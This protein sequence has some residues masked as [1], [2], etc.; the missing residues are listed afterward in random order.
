MVVDLCGVRFL[1]V[2]GADW[3]DAAVG[4]LRE[5]GRTVRVVCADRGPVWRSVCLLGLDRQW[6]VHHDV[7]RAVASLRLDTRGAGPVTPDHRPADKGRSPC[8][9]RRTGCLA[10]EVFAEATSHESEGVMFSKTVVVGVDGSPE[11][12]AALRFALEDAHRRGARVKAVTA[13]LSPEY[14]AA[15][16]GLSALPTIEEVVEDNVIVARE[17]LQAVVAGAPGLA[18]VPVDIVALPGAP[19]K[20]LL[21]QAQDAELLVVGHRGRGGFKSAVL[22]SVGMHC[23]LHA[24]VPVTVVRPQQ[25]PADAPRAGRRVG[26]GLGVLTGRPAT[27]SPPGGN[28]SSR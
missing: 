22:G 21:E 10:S 5:R 3:V 4:A 18:D 20:V 13:Y 1:A 6:P 27:R 16:Y 14:W 24:T 12:R 28:R 19:A 15:S 17:A 2:A 25:E 9:A 11:S 26:P 8:A 7:T 23:V